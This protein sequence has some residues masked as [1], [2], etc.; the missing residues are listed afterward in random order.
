MLKQ[1]EHKIEYW[2]D[3]AGQGKYTVYLTNKDIAHAAKLQVAYR[4]AAERY[5]KLAAE[6]RRLEG[7]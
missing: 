3:S 2:Y 4:L 7:E 6:C 1:P 5:E